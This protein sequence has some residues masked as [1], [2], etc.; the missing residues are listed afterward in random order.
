MSQLYTGYV[1]HLHHCC[2]VVFVDT[3]F[4]STA[5]D[6]IIVVHVIVGVKQTLFTKKQSLDQ[7]QHT[8]INNVRT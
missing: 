5:V 6:S 4:L 1:S 2:L 7:R 8:Y 3:F